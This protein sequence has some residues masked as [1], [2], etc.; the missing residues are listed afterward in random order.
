MYMKNINM[1]WKFLLASLL[2]VINVGMSTLD[3]QTFQKRCISSYDIETIRLN[4]PERY[5]EILKINTQR[6]RYN[7]TIQTREVNDPAATIIIPVVVHII[8]FGEAIGTGR[9]I[10][11]AQIRS[12]IEVLNQDYRRLNAN[13]TATPFAFQSV[14]GDARIEFRLACLDP[15]GASTSGI[16]RTRTTEYSLFLSL[17][18]IEMVLVQS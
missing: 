16:T 15:N 3:A 1:N 17:K 8:H 14:A 13:R 5:Q 2:L 18:T 12:Q 9:N 10:S 7:Q 4:D 11:D 6:T